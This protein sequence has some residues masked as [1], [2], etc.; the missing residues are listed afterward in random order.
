MGNWKLVDT[1]LGQ[2]RE[3]Q[4]EVAV[5]PVGATEAHNL[6]LPYGTDTFAVEAI[7]ERACQRADAQGAR[8]LLLPAI[9]ISVNENTLGF[10]WT[11]S[12]RPST[13][14]RIV[15]DV[16]S[17]LEHNGIPKLL[18]L[19]G[20]GGNEFKPHLREL[21]RQTSVQIM[22][23]DWWTC[24][25]E[26][27]AS[28]F[29]NPGEHGDEMEPSLLLHL[30]PDLVNMHSADA[31]STR[32]PRL[33]AMRE[34]WGWM[35]RPGEKLTTNSGVGDPAAATA[36]KGEQF[37]ARVTAKIAQLILELSNTPVDDMYPYLDA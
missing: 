13:L 31:G 28:I 32:E 29:D 35:A 15:T 6:H 4:Y 12:L 1:N 18:L 26:G 11:M 7:A 36:E 24:D 34:G 16:V 23:V 5:L 22:L 19:N 3:E 2:A 20:H 10:P 25:P 33:T 14:F 9:P 27:W 17:C 21:C 37:L 30:R 8:V